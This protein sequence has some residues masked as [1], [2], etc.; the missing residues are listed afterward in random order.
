MGLKPIIEGLLQEGLLEPCMS[1][2]NTPILSV[3]K[4]DGSYHL[5]QDL[6]AINQIVKTKHLVV[7]NSYT[8]LSKIPFDH[9]WFSV[10]DLKDAFWACPLD[11]DSRDILAFKWE[12]PV[13]GR[14]QQYRWTVLPQ[15]FTDSPHLLGANFRTGVGRLYTPS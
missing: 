8:P 14:R 12:D 10:I 1:S 2:Y 15:G 9:Q 7:P 5:V 4:A 11:W 3:H 6:Q 13:T